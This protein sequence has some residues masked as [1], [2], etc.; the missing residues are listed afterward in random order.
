[1]AYI[2]EDNINNQVLTKIKPYDFPLIIFRFTSPPENQYKRE[3]FTTQELYL[4][5]MNT[6]LLMNVLTKELVQKR[7]LK[8]GAQE[9]FDIAKFAKKSSEFVRKRN[10]YRN[11]KCKVEETREEIRECIQKSKTAEHNAKVNQSPQ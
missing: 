5:L 6:N 3:Y 7:F 11:I 8:Q 1:M 2:G 10:D 9:R 4:R